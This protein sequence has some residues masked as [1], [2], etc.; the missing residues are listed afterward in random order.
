MTMIDINYIIQ[1]LYWLTPISNRT[2]LLHWIARLYSNY[3]TVFHQTTWLGYPVTTVLTNVNI[4]KLPIDMHSKSYP[5]VKCTY[6]NIALVY[7]AVYE[8]T[9]YNYNLLLKF[10]MDL[11]IPAK[12]IGHSIWCTISRSEHSVSS[13]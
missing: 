1:Y 12:A 2:S 8:Y 4:F 10:K 5:C 6:Y 13:L 9:V 7:F 3:Y 11:R